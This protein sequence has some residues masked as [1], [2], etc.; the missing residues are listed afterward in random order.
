MTTALVP[1]TSHGGPLA[2]SGCG[3]GDDHAHG[4]L[5]A[6]QRNHFF[7]RKLMEVCHWQAE[8]DYHR[9]AR[10]LVTRL[11]LLTCGQAGRS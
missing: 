6:L 8:Q 7:P 1:V 10:E 2:R 3:C 5:R 11:G 9:H 4:G